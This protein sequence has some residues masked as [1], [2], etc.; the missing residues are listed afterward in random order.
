MRESAAVHATRIAISLMICKIIF[1]TKC[2]L[3]M[4]GSR[5]TAI[6]VR[7][8]ELFACLRISPHS[9]VQLHNLKMQQPMTRQ[10][11]AISGMDIQQRN[12]RTT[13]L[14]EFSLQILKLTSSIRHSKGKNDA[15]LQ[16]LNYIA[17][18]CNEYFSLTIL[19]YRYILNHGPLEYFFFS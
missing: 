16:I 9:S 17:Q 19:N 14:H 11:G 10:E 6:C 5:E 4:Y 13:Y 12:V 8:R 1:I 7:E 15:L 18:L 3:C 2:Q